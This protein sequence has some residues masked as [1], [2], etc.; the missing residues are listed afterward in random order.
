MRTQLLQK[1][2][3]IQSNS[4]LLTIT[5]D[6]EE[7]L[8]VS[9]SADAVI[10]IDVRDLTGTAS[11]TNIYLNLES[12][13]SKDES[14]FAAVVPPVQ[15]MTQSTPIL[16]RTTRRAVSVSP[17][18]RWLRWRL[19]INVGS[20][21][22]WGATFRIRVGLSKTP[23]FTP[24]ELSGCLLWLRSDLGLPASI[25][26]GVAVPA[27]T[28][29]K[30]QSG[31]SGQDATVTNANSDLTYNLNGV[32]GLPY[33]ANTAGAAA[34]FTGTINAGFGAAHT[35]FAVANATAPAA[36][37]SGLFAATIGGAIDTSFSIW[38]NHTPSIVG[39]TS[40]SGSNA[41]PDVVTGASAFFGSLQLFAADAT[42]NA[43]KANLYINGSTAVGNSPVSYVFNPGVPNGYVVFDRASTGPDPLKFNAAYEFLVYNRQLLKAE[44]AA[45]F[46]YLSNRYGVA[47]TS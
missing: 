23:L 45:V 18:G 33:F 43:G 14:L 16:A 29:W 37:P 12:A 4:S 3:R 22:S 10:W 31:Q 21:G 6:E 9:E 15:L 36:G 41:D 39:R 34:Y 8:D 32:N 47:L 26:G 13:P 17:L 11:G 1:W 20:S 19:N 30:D 40:G 25:P 44:R 28:T 7:W 42:G 5:Q 24:T 27:A 46:Q 35:V 2:T 38:F